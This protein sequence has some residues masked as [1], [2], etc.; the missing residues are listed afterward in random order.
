[1]AS[2]EH[3]T[4]R[5]SGGSCRVS[6]DEVR[7]N[8]LRWR[9]WRRLYVF[10]RRRNTVSTRLWLLRIP[11]PK[12]EVPFSQIAYL[13]L[14]GEVE[15]YGVFGR[16]PKFSVVMALAGQK[17]QLEVAKVFYGRRIGRFGSPE[18]AHKRAETIEEALREVPGLLR[19]QKR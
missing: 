12:M 19:S 17:R 7:V 16:F 5:F 13:G 14:H 9:C 3:Q 15:Y 4:I 1:M 11:L 8:H 2:T 18:E 6:Q 10:D